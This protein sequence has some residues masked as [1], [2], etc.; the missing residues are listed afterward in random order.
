MAMPALLRFKTSITAKLAARWPQ[1]L[2][3][4]IDQFMVAAK[5][6]TVRTASAS[7][8]TAEQ[9]IDWADAATHEFI[10]ENHYLSL[11]RDERRSFGLS[12][13]TAV[14]YIICRK[15]QVKPN[16]LM[17]SADREY[18]KSSKHRTIDALNH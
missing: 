9:F 1:A 18:L 11:E 4:Q 13:T 3:L 12:H 16:L 15:M 14:R 5:N 2:P 6:W 7:M 10:T 17:K 8:V